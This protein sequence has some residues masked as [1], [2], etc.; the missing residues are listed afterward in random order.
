MA[1]VQTYQYDRTQLSDSER[2]VLEHLEK[3]GEVI[4]EIWQRQ[5]DQDTGEIL[6]YPE[7]ASKEE[8]M[9]AAKADPKILDSYTVVKKE[10]GNIIAVPYQEEYS[11]LLEKFYSHLQSASEETEEEPLR[12]YIQDTV[13]YYKKGDFIA[14]L[15]AY[16]ENPNTKIEFLAGPIET[17]EDQLFG[18]KKTFQ[19]NLRVLKDDYTD[20]VAQ[21]YD[22]MRNIKLPQPDT[23]LG[24]T[25][26]PGRIKVRIDDVIMFAG[27]QATSLVSSTNLPNES[28]LTEQYGTKV[29]VY[30]TSMGLKFDTRQEPLLQYFDDQS[31]VSDKAG[32]RNAM[33]RFISLHEI[34]EGTI[35]FR[36]MEER[37]G[38]HYAFI[39]ELNAHLAGLDSA[40][41]QLMNG[42][43]DLPGY[44]KLLAA[45]VTY[46]VDV[47][48]LYQSKGKLAD[49]AKGFAVSFN[50]FSDFGSMTFH[51]GSI[52]LDY[53]KLS[54]DIERLSNIVLALLEEGTES[55][56]D[57]LWEEYGDYSLFDQLPKPEID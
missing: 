37:L 48:N 38:R 28:V 26:E 3:A 49:Y 56:I 30:T 6:L 21:M 51:S 8:I 34:A 57:K 35:K 13:E 36:G 5:V 25:I 7:D 24:S 55:D 31:V 10:N 16:V 17:Y 19:Y 32:M 44:Q 52:Q 20:E 23:S 22:V 11:D 54:R 4:H 53:A 39:R 43:M 1:S 12:I 18:R 45:F 27:R 47:A 33:F 42:I 9:D 46:G 14:A 50:F 2:S 29:A 41:Y 40:K 15:I